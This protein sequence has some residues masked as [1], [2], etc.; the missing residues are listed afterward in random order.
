M[1]PRSAESP[2]E[3]VFPRRRVAG[4]GTPRQA[5]GPHSLAVLFGKRDEDLLAAERP[6]GEKRAAVKLSRDD[7]LHEGRL[8]V[9]PGEFVTGAS[10]P[11]AP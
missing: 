9:D 1:P 2:P 4:G 10:F 11:R 3:Q 7:E 6:A 8:G 5:R